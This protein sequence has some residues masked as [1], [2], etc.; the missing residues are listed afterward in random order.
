MPDDIENLL[1]RYRPVG[2]PSTLRQKIVAALPVERHWP[3]YIFRA[4][5]A[6]T[7]LI[8]VGLLYAAD[9]LNRTN[10]DRIGTGPVT[11]TPETQQRYVAQLLH[12]L[13]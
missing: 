10:A 4:A 11:W 8:S 6:A 12:D 1:Q 3:L 9:T 13:R 2:P 7:L 5:I